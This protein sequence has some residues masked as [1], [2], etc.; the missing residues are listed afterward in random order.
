MALHALQKLRMYT[1]IYGKH[2]RKTGF[3]EALLRRGICAHVA[4][5]W[6]KSS[7]SSLDDTSVWVILSDS[8]LEPRRSDVFAAFLRPFKRACSGVSTH[9]SSRGGRGTLSAKR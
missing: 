6:W 4:F 2:P 8:S 9:H 7:H 3:Y 5:I 1:V